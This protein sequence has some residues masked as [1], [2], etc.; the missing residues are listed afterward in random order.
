MTASQTTTSTQTTGLQANASEQP[1]LPTI[2]DAPRTFELTNCT[3]QDTGFPWPG[4]AAPGQ[5]PPGWEPSLALASNGIISFY[6]CERF[7]WGP[8]ERPIRIAIEEHD[9]RVAPPACEQAGDYEVSQI[10]ERLWIDDPEIVEYLNTT[11]SLPARFAA[12]AYTDT[13]SAGVHQRVWSLT[14]P[15]A[16][17]STLNFLRPPTDDRPGGTFGL[18]LV[19]W[20]GSVLGYLD[21]TQTDTYREP[22]AMP[23]YGHMEPPTLHASTGLSEWVGAG[24][25]HEAMDASGMILLWRDSLCADPL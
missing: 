3:N 15:G 16:Q 25:W 4:E 5:V 8:Y 10:I 22:G 12:I 9:K 1:I 19:W 23:V 21:L 24:G 7:A 2:A 20:S 11:Y 14:P 13:I 6:D 18:R 17:P